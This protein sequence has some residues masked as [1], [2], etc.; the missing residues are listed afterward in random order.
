MTGSALRARMLL[1]EAHSLGLDLADLIAAD[2]AGAARMPTVRA[3]VEA[4]A[5]TFSAAT[6]ATYRPYWRLA[7]ARLGARRLADVTLQ[8][9]TAV[10]DDAGARAQRCRPD[11]TGRASRESCVAA[12][13]AVFRRATNA[14]LITVNPAASLTKPRRVRS[15]RRALDDSEL[16]EVIDAVRT[17]SR[18]PDLDL[19]VIRF[20]LESGARREGALNLRRRD[21]DPKRATVWLREKGDSEREQPVSPSLVALLERHANVRASAHL[22]EPVFRTSDGAVMSARRY[23]TVFVHARACLDWSDRTPVSAHVLRH[24]AITAVGRLAG[25]PAAQ[26]FAG[27]APPSITGRYLHASLAEVA[28]AVA[29]LTGEPHPLADG[30]HRSGTRVGSSMCGRR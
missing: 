24:T 7:A 30:R 25:Y 21:L 17:T 1:E 11:S 2:T 6:A 19:L 18:D 5:P 20:H 28:G 16:A 9:L 12:L 15:R 26:A 29:A 23:D 4:I 8:D 14:G 27:H 13:R 3:Y 10:V 22:D